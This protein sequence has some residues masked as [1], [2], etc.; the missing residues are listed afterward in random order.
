MLLDLNG[1]ICFDT[2]SKLDRYIGKETCVKLINQGTDLLIFLEGTWNIT[3]ILPVMGLYTG[4]VQIALRIGAEVIHIAI[5]QYN[6]DYYINIGENIDWNEQ[7][8][9]NCKSLTAELRDVL[10]L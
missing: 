2:D 3:E 10:Q 6:N 8:I 1:V 9:D 5:E 7:S 4:T